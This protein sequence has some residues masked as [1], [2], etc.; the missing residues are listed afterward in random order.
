MR[1]LLNVDVIGQVAGGSAKF[2][3]LDFQLNFPSVLIKVSGNEMVLAVDRQEL[4][5]ILKF[6]LSE[7]HVRL[8]LKVTELGKGNK[9]KNAEKFVEFDLSGE[10][11]VLIRIPD[12][13]ATRVVDRQELA[14]ALKFVL[15]A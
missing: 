2:L 10:T 9:G 4:A 14:Y 13:E 15:S 7:G 3:E 5:P 8:S 6:I 12:D 11:V 1:I